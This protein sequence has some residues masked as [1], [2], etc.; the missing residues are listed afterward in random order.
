[1]NATVSADP[2]CPLTLHA[3]APA[4]PRPEGLAG[5]AVGLMDTLGGPGAALVVG[6]ENVF[7]PIPSE[8]ILP[9]AGFAAAQGAFSVLA[10]IVWTTLG[11]VVGALAAYALGRG[12]GR[13]RVRALADR[14]PLLRVADV[15]RTSQWFARY[16][17]W[18]VLFGRM[19]PLV[20]SVISIPAGVERMNVA[21]FLV[22]TTVGSLAWNSLF[23]LGGYALGAQWHRIESVAG[24]LSNIV[25]A[26]LVV[27][28]LAFF[29]RRLL[30]GL[31]R[32]K[33]TPPSTDPLST[34]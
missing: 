15:D 5:W 32:R 33:Q 16:G 9:L 14:I 17:T 27:V 7:P 34:G 26:S 29:G 13:D 20:R 10:A 30:I 22:L 6:L 18:S 12:L 28:C 3:Q 11:S 1:M 25:V 23:V 4:A 19:V 21:V 2:T 31:R 24:T 8:V